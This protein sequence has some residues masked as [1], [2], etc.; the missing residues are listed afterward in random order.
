MIW[1][2][3]GLSYPFSNT[4][5]MHGTKMIISVF[6]VLTTELKRIIHKSEVTLPYFS[7][8]AHRHTHTPKEGKTGT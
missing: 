6:C 7:I 3:I 1:L 8:S 4:A 2:S 5:R